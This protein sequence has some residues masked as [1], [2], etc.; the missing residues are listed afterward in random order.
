MPDTNAINLV[1]I[2]IANSIGLLVLF[3]CA[4]GNMYRAKKKTA[5]SISILTLLV[6]LAFCSI[7][8]TLTSIINGSVGIVSQT[9]F[10][11]F[12]NIFGNTITFIGNILMACCWSIFLI[13]HLN[14]FVRKERIIVLASIFGA[15][16]IAMI[17][18]AFVPFVFSVDNEGVYHRETVGF[19][20]NVIIALI[21]LVVEPVFNFIR[22]KRSGGLLKFFPVWLFYIPT[23]AG[24]LFQML[25]YGICT[26]YVGLCLGMCG[27]IM[28]SQNDM[29]FRDKLTSLYNRYYLDKLKERMMRKSGEANF[30]AMMLDLNGFK[31]IND[32]YG[33][34]VGDEALIYTGN[35]LRESVGS[36]GTVIR[37]AGD[38]FVVI[39]NTNSDDLI[40]DR[41]LL[42]RRAFDAF[43]DKKQVPYTLSISIGYA[44]ADLKHSTIDEL[45]NE[46]DQKMYEDKV[47]Q[48]EFHPE[49]ER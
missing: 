30:T 18:N 10:T 7:F 33:H 49:W 38:E 2:I 12:L 16:S 3:I 48:H 24:I 8:E 20:V 31:K 32:T 47:K 36:F 19:I 39:L 27:I 11:K 37:Y 1:E 44:K 23:G 42:I 5:E 28:G 15:Y 43:N 26:I 9:E 29:I 21:L 35:L 25:N 4:F 14:G 46:I 22:I 45:M 17:V 6:T 34:Q 41:V 40:K 13:A